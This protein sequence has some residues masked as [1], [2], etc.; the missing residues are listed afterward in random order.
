M[1]ACSNLSQV[2]DY[3]GQST[4]VKQISIIVVLLL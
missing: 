1:L 2:H 3:V 4:S